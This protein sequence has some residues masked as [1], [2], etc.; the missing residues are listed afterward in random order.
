MKFSRQGSYHS[1]TAIICCLLFVTSC[2]EPTR[3]VTTT[4]KSKNELAAEVSQDST[5][6]DSV[7]TF[8]GTSNSAAA[9]LIKEDPDILF[10]KWV[11][12]DGVDG[13]GNTI[14]I[15]IIL[16]SDFTFT[17]KF[18][19]QQNTGTYSISEDYLS[20]I[21]ED[22]TISNNWIFQLDPGYMKLILD[23]DIREKA[24][25]GNYYKK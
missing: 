13:E 3:S 9:D 10:G 15:T 17:T 20:V 7:Y 8:I 5:S 12:Q 1:L 22:G 25:T 6:V 4:N 2:N 16:R 14:D 23:Y 18:N 11:L 21:N 24:F 19:G